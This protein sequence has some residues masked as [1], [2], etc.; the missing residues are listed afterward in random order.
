MT[1]PEGIE[2][3]D[4]PVDEDII[5]DDQPTQPQTTQPV[6]QTDLSREEQ[7]QVN[8][9]KAAVHS[10]SVKLPSK[11][12]SVEDWVKSTRELQKAYTQTRQELAAAKQS[13]Q[14]DAPQTNH[15][16][17]Q[18]EANTNGVPLNL[19]DALDEP[20]DA[21]TD[22]AFS[23]EEFNSHLTNGGEVS[24][25]W[26]EK[27]KANNIPKAVLDNLANGVTAQKR[28]VAAETYQIM[29][30]EQQYADAVQWARRNLSASEKADLKA[31]LSSTGWRTALRWLKQE[32]S[33]RQSAQVSKKK[34]P[35]VDT[36]IPHQNDSALE[37]FNSQDEVAAAMRDPKYRTD[38]QYRHEVQKRNAL[39]LQRGPAHTIRS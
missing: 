26:V 14:N 7:S 20:A 16:G 2:A 27:A 28:A 30:G 34:T 9:L 29:G 38:P 18:P 25:E 3:L 11:F 33:T 22:T 32:M 37:P 1:K 21:E 5:E 17:L 23:W 39:F 35:R 10:G 36:Q 12:K 19:A 13:T 24:D 6:Q 8:A 15:H 4:E 31:A